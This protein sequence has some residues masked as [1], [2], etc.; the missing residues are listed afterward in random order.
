MGSYSLV[1][2][3]VRLLHCVVL[4][5]VGLTFHP[6]VARPVLCSTVYQTECGTSNKELE[7]EEDKVSRKT[8]KET[9]CQEKVAGYSKKVECKEW[10][11]EECTITREIV[12]KTI[13]DTRC[14]KIP[15]RICV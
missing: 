6:S 14:E 7:V 15:T 3:M 8:V 13:P 11:R 10:P 5:L 9:K 4:V 1:S 2:N 12:T